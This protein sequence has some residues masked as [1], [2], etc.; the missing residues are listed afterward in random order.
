MLHHEGNTLLNPADDLRLTAS[1][2][3]GGRIPADAF[4]LFL[5]GDHS[6]SGFLV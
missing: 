4:G 2:N 6:D 3:S 1:S 5:H